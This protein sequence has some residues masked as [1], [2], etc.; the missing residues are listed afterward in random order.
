MA[1][2]MVALLLLGGLAQAMQSRGGKCARMA[3]IVV[4]SLLMLLSVCFMVTISSSLTTDDWREALAT[5]EAPRAVA[6]DGE[7]EDAQ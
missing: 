5:G 2:S 6:T 1:V 3:P 4:L 7:V